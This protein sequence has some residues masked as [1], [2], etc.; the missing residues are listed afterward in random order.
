MHPI[1]M[2]PTPAYVKSVSAYLD[3]AWLTRQETFDGDV[4]AYEKE[5]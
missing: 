2:S 4:R 1:L 3:M 5:A